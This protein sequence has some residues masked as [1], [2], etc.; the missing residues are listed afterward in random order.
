M[1]KACLSAPRMPPLRPL[2]AICSLVPGCSRRPC[3]SDRPACMPCRLVVRYSLPGA[4][5][6]T[7]LGCPL[8]E[9]PRAPSEHWF[10][11]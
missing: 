7:G 2:G 4:V 5:V 6:L 1:P 3:R 9:G 8:P 10:R 11:R